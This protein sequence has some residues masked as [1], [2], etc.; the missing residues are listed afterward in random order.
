MTVPVLLKDAQRY[1]SA[2]PVRTSGDIV[3]QSS[4]PRT[5]SPGKDSSCNVAQG[6]CSTPYT[7]R[8]D[9]P[10]PLT[11]SGTC[12]LVSNAD[13]FWFRQYSGHTIWFDRL[14]LRFLDT[15]AKGGTLLFW[16]PDIA[17]DN[18]LYLTSM[19]LQCDGSPKTRALWSSKSPSYASGVHSHRACG[20][21]GMG[22]ADES[23][24]ADTRTAAQRLI[25]SCNCHPRPMSQ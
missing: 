8:L 16:E 17:K 14:A 20:S 21:I 5:A 15:S 10:L 24:T 2:L 22:V 3:M 25:F 23:E 9:P 7:K 6:N 12:V 18:A 4:A 19:V 1:R 11:V 13:I